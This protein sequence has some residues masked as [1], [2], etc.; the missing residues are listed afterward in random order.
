MWADKESGKYKG[1]DWEVFV[2]EHININVILWGKATELLAFSIRPYY[3]P[4]ECC[5]H[6]SEVVTSLWTSTR[7]TFTPYVTCNP[8]D[9][10]ILNRFHTS[11]KEACRSSPPPSPWKIAGR[12]LPINRP[13]SDKVR[14]MWLWRTFSI[15]LH[16]KFFVV[17]MR[18]TMITRVTD[19]I[20]VQ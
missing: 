5:R 19:V 13:H 17:V 20:K 9:H 3:L 8:T 12:L 10:K 2:D 14:L 18:R 4:W 11:T 15:H 6:S 7:P 16:G 1:G